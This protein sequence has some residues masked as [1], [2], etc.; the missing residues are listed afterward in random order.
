MEMACAIAYPVE[1][2][3]QGP[4][5]VLDWISSWNEYLIPVSHDGYAAALDQALPVAPAETPK[6]QARQVAS[7]S[8]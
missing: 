8:Q 5:R 7:N 1:T 3:H 2:V 6:I 4:N